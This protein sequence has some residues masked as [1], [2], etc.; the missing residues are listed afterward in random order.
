V[1][2]GRAIRP[3]LVAAAGATAAAL[4]L[5]LPPQPAAQPRND[6]DHLRSGFP[7]TG[8]HERA[9]CEGCHLR[10]L[11]EGTPT[12]CGT[13]HANGA[14][15]QARGK[16]RDHVPSSDECGDCHV[17]RAWTPARFD[18]AGV[19]GRCVSCHNGGFAEGKPANH[20]P[21]TDDCE[22]CH[23]TLAW[24]PAGFDH[25]GITGGC[26]NC[27]NGTTATGKP[28]NHV[29]SSNAC[30]D[31]HQ[32]RSWDV[33][34]GF[35][36][37]GITGNCFSC[38]NGTTATGKPS[39]HVPSANTCED[40]H[41]TMS[42]ATAGGFDH[43]GITGNCASCH[44]G[45]SAT[46][47]PPNHFVTSLD[48]VDCHSPAGWLPARYQHMSASYPGDHA[49][50]LDCQACHTSNAQAVPWR[51]A[52]YAPDCAGCHANDFRNEHIKVEQPRILYTVSE[53]RDCA[54]ACHTY[55]DA[56]FTTIVRTRTG[57]HRVNRLDW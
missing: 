42:W 32:T 6:F 11:F 36:H 29:P 30:E 18:H 25:S 20:V 7:L 17:T 27:H 10:G 19:S 57:E 2:G 12:R 24:V 38:H 45:S 31:C 55:S 21:S 16:P 1:R 14:P 22:T 28:P 54:G 46:G 3:R 35:D 49:G 33:A 53:L 43:S 56:S 47:K 51:F 40:C 8:A 37:S 15:W 26:F 34:G 4:L 5:A 48:C 23:R 44:N 50:N 52:A 41:N 13:C 9:P 39:N